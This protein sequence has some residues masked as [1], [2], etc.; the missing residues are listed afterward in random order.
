MPELNQL[1]KL[2]NASDIDSTQ[3]DE[4]IQKI[5]EHLDIKPE[6]A[7]G[8]FRRVEVEVPVEQTEG[9]KALDALKQNFDPEALYSLKQ[10][11]N[12]TMRRP[13]LKR[14]ASRKGNPVT[15]IDTPREVEPFYPEICINASTKLNYLASLNL[16]KF[17]HSE[18]QEVKKEMIKLSTDIMEMEATLQAIKSLLK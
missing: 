11:A 2:L 13:E 15:A 3:Y 5:K 18:M 8:T 10:K 1:L 16:S 6:P 9:V 14:L 4:T 17:S 7:K 12:A